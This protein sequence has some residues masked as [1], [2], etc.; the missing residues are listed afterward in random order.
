MGDLVVDTSVRM[1]RFI[2]KLWGECESEV[3]ESYL[4]AD[5]W[6]RLAGYWRTDKMRQTETAA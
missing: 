1:P 2:S 6:A 3:R 4:M 5:G